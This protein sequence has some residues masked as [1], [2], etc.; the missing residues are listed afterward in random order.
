MWVFCW[1]KDGRKLRNGTHEAEDSRLTLN[2][3]VDLFPGVCHHCT[4]KR[5]VDDVDSV[6]ARTFRL[7]PTVAGEMPAVNTQN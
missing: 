4:T 1:H 7:E 2:D 5:E 6:L 3:A